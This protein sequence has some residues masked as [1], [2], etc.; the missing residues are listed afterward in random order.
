MTMKRGEDV[1]IPGHRNVMKREAEI[2]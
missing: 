2:L 1:A